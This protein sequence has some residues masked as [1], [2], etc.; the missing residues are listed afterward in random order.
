MAIVQLSSIFA[1]IRRL[2]GSSDVLQL[3]D[4]ANPT[5]PNS[6]GLADYVNSF[7]LYD[8]PAEYRSLKLK[9]KLTFNTVYGVDTYPFDSEKYLTV[10]MPCYCAKREILLFNDPWSFY[11]VN[12]NWQY[13]TNFAYGNG[14]TG[15]YSGFTTATPIIRSVNNI[16]YYNQQINDIIVDSPSVGFT[17][18][19]FVTNEFSASQLVTFSQVTGTVAA[20]LNGFTFTITSVTANSLV[21]PAISTG[22]TYTGGGYATSASSAINYPASRV[23]N[24]LITTNISN[25]DTLNVTDDGFGN[26]IGDCFSGQINYATGQITNLSFSQAVPGSTP[27]Q[28][29][30]NPVVPSIPLSI[31]FFQNQF[32]LRP[33]PSGG[34]TI[35][36]IAHRQPT[37]ALMSAPSETG[38]PELSEWWECI[39]CGAAKKIFEDRMDTDGILLMDKM[40]QERYDVVYTRTYAQLGKQRIRT[41]FD[42]QNSQNYGSGPFGFGSGGF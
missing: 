12:Y 25:G 21:I 13:C 35:E 17:T 3:P 19:N 28:I 31:L 11:G 1:K 20:I 41:I 26:L 34:F 8:F 36:L 16:P 18:I 24:I 37:Q 32:T 39:A 4:Y 10:E 9:D 40:L 30:Y 22:L 27:I 15:P 42:N 23:Q 14:T 38:V 6:V 29:Q 2:T 7:Y 33:V 5:D